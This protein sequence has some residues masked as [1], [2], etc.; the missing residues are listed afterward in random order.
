MNDSNCPSTAVLLAVYSNDSFY[1]WH[2]NVKNVE[3][4]SRSGSFFF[5]CIFL[6]IYN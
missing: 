1:T 6:K 2:L 4:T 3:K 5:M